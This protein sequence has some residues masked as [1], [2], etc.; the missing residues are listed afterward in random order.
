MTRAESQG[1]WTLLSLSHYVDIGAPEIGNPVGIGFFARRDTA[2][3]DASLSVV[4]E[5]TSMCLVGLGLGGAALLAKR[6]RE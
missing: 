6:R 2:V 3:D 1:N 4:P 5:P